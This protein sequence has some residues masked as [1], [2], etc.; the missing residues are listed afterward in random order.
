MS[1]DMAIEIENDDVLQVILSNFAEDAI[2]A[3]I[4]EIEDSI[5][6]FIRRDTY[7]VAQDDHP[8]EWYYDGT[9]EPT[10]QFLEA[11][12]FDDDIRN[13]FDEVEATLF[14]DWESM[15]V[16]ISTKLHSEG[17]DFREKMAGAFNVDGLV[18]GEV[19][20]RLRAPYWNNFIKEMIQNEFV[21]NLLDAVFSEFGASRLTIE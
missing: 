19:M 3:I 4:P 10:Y 9:A 18:E 17:G 16:D 21:Q 2:R 12:H 5:W 6:G 7:E 11:F 13:N 1:D 8:R 20:A 14:Y 15:E